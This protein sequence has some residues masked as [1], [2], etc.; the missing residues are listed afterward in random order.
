MLYHAIGLMSG[1]SLDGLD[2]CHASFSHTSA[3]GWKYRI[4]NC[5]TVKYSAE[6][7][8]ALRDARTLSAENLFALNASYGKYLGEKVN[9]FIQRIGLTPPDVIG[10]HGHTVYHQPHRGFTVQIGDGRAIRMINDVPV[11]YDFRSADVM[12]GGNGAPLV[13]VG[14]RH[15]FA[16]YGACLNL[17]GFSNISLEYAG[18]RIAFDICPV[19]T[20]FNRFAQ[21]LGEPFDRGGKLAAA[22]TVDHGVLQELNKLDFYQLSPPKSLGAEWVDSQVF[23]ML[24]HLSARDALATFAEHAAIQIALVL[25]N[26]KVNNVLVTG[27]GAYNKYLLERI[28]ARTCCKLTVPDNEV[29]EFK[30]ALIFAFMAVLRLRG[31]NNVLSSATGSDRDHCSGI[32]V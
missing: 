1:T 8:Q 17:G 13:P 18:Q 12:R 31:E 30:E 16:E 32:L 29:V 3:E 22:G 6:W 25:E 7:E 24:E 26:Y 11:V 14:D 4:L 19:N 10:S 27:G 5:E 20:V 21:L 15:L 23:P 2:I 28:A 9:L